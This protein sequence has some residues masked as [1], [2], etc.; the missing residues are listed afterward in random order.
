MLRAVLGSCLNAALQHSTNEKSSIFR[1]IVKNAGTY[2]CTR[3]VLRDHVCRLLLV[4]ED[5][6]GRCVLTAVENLE[7]FLPAEIL[8]QVT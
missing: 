5:D 1:K 2:T 7:E 3:K 6:N 4:D 8:S